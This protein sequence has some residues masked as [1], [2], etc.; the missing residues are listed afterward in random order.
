MVNYQ[1]IFLNSL[2]V[3]FSPSSRLTI[4]S[5]PRFL[6]FWIF[7][8]FLG[9]PSGIFLSQIISPSK[10]TFSEI[11]VAKSFIEISLPVPTFKNLKETIIKNVIPALNFFY[12]RLFL[13]VARFIR[14]SFTNTFKNIKEAIFGADGQGGPGSL[15]YS[16]E[17]FKKGDIFG[18]LKNTVGTLFT[19]F[20]KIDISEISSEILRTVKI[21]FLAFACFFSICKGHDPV[22]LTQPMKDTITENL[23]K[24]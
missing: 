16:L 22:A 11:L 19:F 8:T 7:K 20:K 23:G 12:D 24:N 6:I 3:L 10:P 15:A 4:G 2:I 1:I 17:L 13:P 21:V 9:V 5:H 18:A 14:F